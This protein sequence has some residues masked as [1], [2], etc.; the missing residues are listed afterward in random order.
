MAVQMTSLSPTTHHSPPPAARSI[1]DLFFFFFFFFFFRE[2]GFFYP[3]IS[4]ENKY[5]S[6]IF[7]S[8]LLSPE[9]IP[10]F[11]VRTSFSISNPIL[12][13]IWLSNIF[14][15]FLFSIWKKPW[16]NTGIGA[17][18]ICYKFFLLL[19]DRGCGA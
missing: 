17:G 8:T 4:C 3:L 2:R 7:G 6:I 14:S 16:D 5:P 10:F 1:F 13:I 15:L 19:V 12:A 18:F 9:F 11:R